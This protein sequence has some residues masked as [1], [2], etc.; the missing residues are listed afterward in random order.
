MVCVE[1]KSNLGY[2]LH[3]KVNMNVAR[4]VI[5]VLYKILQD[6]Q[7][8]RLCEYFNIANQY[9]L[10]KNRNIFFMKTACRENKST[11]TSLS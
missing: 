3:H 7:K 8:P 5:H 2:H 11:R 10:C 4:L 9:L 1:T 6:S